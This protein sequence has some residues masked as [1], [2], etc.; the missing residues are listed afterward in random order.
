MSRRRATG[1][2]VLTVLLAVLTSLFP[3]SAPAQA[4]EVDETI[5]YRCSSSFGS[6]ASGVRVRVTIPDRVRKGVE[7]PART[8][9]FS[10]KVPADMVAAMRSYGV[11]SV[12]AEGRASYLVGGLRRPI[13]N[14]QI[15]DT[16]VP[17]GGGMTL[18]GEGRAAA[19]T[20]EESGT[21]AVKVTKSLTATATASGG[22]FSGASV[23]LSCSVR[24]GESRRLATLVVV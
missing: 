16:D 22:P 2:A 14:L 24:R 5:G 7:V 20:L 18:R 15:P 8:V 1:F 13:R 10:I 9:R 17:A 19:F 3:G 12:S 21:F 6:G 23:D 4:T 11:D